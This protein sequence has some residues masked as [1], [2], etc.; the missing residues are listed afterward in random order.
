MCLLPNKIDT[1]PGFGWEE[2]QL[3]IKDEEY[4]SCR[5]INFFIPFLIMKFNRK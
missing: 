1:P 4:S 2:C 5:Y 3:I